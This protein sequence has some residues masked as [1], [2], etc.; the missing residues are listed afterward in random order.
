MANIFNRE[1][2]DSEYFFL[3]VSITS[4]F[5]WPR[6]KP[7]AF[8]R[9][10]TFAKS[11]ESKLTVKRDYKANDKSITIPS[12]KLNWGGGCRAG[13][14]GIR[15]KSAQVIQFCIS[16]LKDTAHTF[17]SETEF[18]ILSFYFTVLSM[19]GASR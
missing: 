6:Q 12:H 2:S 5:I 7:N 9:I 15:V 11:S 16:G 8:V 17:I 4:M 1:Q 14:Q 13:E 18:S 3:L 10:F 19:A